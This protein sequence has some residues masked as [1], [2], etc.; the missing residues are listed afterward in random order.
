MVF[1]R[2]AWALAQLQLPC[3]SQPYRSTVQIA[4]RPPSHPALT[5]PRPSGCQRGPRCSQTTEIA[6]DR[7]APHLLLLAP[8]L[9]P[10]PP[11]PPAA[12]RCLP[13]LKRR[14]CLP[15]R[16]GLPAASARSSRHGHARARG[17]TGGDRLVVRAAPL[18][19]TRAPA[20]LRSLFVAPSAQPPG[21][22][23]L[24]P[25]P[26]PPWRRRDHG[27]RWGPSFA[28]ALFGA[29]WW[30]FVDSVAVAS[31]HIPF[32][33]VGAGARDGGARRGGRFNA[34]RGQG[35]GAG[36]EVLGHPEQLPPQHAGCAP[37]L[38][39]H[40]LPR[41]LPPCSSPAVPA[42][43]RGHAGPHHDQL[44]P[45]VGWAPAPAALLS[46]V[47]SRRRPAVGSPRLRRPAAR[48]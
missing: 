15:R 9:P 12:G 3:L 33:Q 43:H 24:T 25:D 7:W 10:P 48:R 37:P 13:L 46:A 42:G 23:P 6:A 30:F 31:S 4:P 16:L 32:S 29:G 20:A 36:A 41:P 18:G 45:P 5:L 35:T 44:H 8:L 21:A 47:C 2:A 17:F 34:R 38:L 39:P 1:E 26:A 27:R 22:L 14:V 28:G 11:L 19:R 40:P